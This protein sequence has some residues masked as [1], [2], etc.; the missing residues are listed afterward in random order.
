MGHM[1]PPRE[2]S[3]SRGGS[4]RK[5]LM[6]AGS[7]RGG[8][9]PPSRVIGSPGYGGRDGDGGIRTGMSRMSG[10]S[11]M[12]GLRE[13]R[14]STPPGGGRLPSRGGSPLGSSRGLARPQSGLS[15]FLGNSDRVLATV[16]VRVKRRLLVDVPGAVI[17]P[18]AL[19]TGAAV[20]PTMNAEQNGRRNTFTATSEGGMGGGEDNVWDDVHPHPPSVCEV[21]TGAECV[22]STD[23]GANDDELHTK[24]TEGDPLRRVYFDGRLEHDVTFDLCDGLGWTLVDREDAAIPGTDVKSLLPGGAADIAQHIQSGDH[25]LAVNGDD[26]GGDDMVS[27][28]ERIDNGMREAARS[29]EMCNSLA[30]VFGRSNKDDKEAETIRTRNRRTAAHHGEDAGASHDVIYVVVFVGKYGM[31]CKAAPWGTGVVVDTVLKGGAAEASNV[32]AVGDHIV[33]V[34]GVD[35]R[36]ASVEAV[37]ELLSG[38]WHPGKDDYEVEEGNVARRETAAES[39]T[40]SSCDGSIDVFRGEDTTKLTGLLIIGDGDPPV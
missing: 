39:R 17:V 23:D 33:E 2:G 7:W 5:L 3:G 13:M 32:V 24:G 28:A 34:A 15:D 21:T 25:I 4:A 35:T 18:A 26:C 31:V 19:G 29:T 9:T 37:A 20:D 30:V 12:S 10:M 8:G 36:E 11:G 6:S 16:A 38:E 22:N 27:V 1:G 14:L 40:H